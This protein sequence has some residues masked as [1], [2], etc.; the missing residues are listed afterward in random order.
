MI[1]NQLDYEQLKNLDT[2]L[3]ILLLICSV[4]HCDLLNS[5]RSGASNDNKDDS[6]DVDKDMMKTS[7]QIGKI[8]EKSGKSN[9]YNGV[10]SDTEDDDSTKKANKIKGGKRWDDVENQWVDVS[11]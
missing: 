5:A 10:L 9:K 7:D 4:R 8:G 1:V 3:I 6:K 11:Q 2:N